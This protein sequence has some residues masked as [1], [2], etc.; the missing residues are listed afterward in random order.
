MEN[1]DFE[2]ISN[3]TIDSVVETP[4]VKQED[5]S[6][7]DTTTIQH[8]T[9]FETKPTTF[10]K[11]SLKRFSKNKSSVVAAGI[12]GAL[13][14]LSFVVPIFNTNNVSKAHPYQTYLEP[15]LFPSG[16]GWWDGTRKYSGI[17]YDTKTGYPDPTGFPA[18]EAI[19]NLK[20]GEKT[21]VNTTSN[22]GVGG[23]IQF[24][25]SEAS[26]TV[27]GG[28]KANT[29]TLSTL[30]FAKELSTEFENTI[31]IVFGEEQEIDYYKFLPYSIYF[32][33]QVYGL[34]EDGTYGYTDKSIPLMENSTNYGTINLDVSNIIKN[35]SEPLTSASKSSISIVISNKD[36]EYK[37]CVL[38]KSVKL[39][40]NSTDEEFKA[41]F[42]APSFDDANKMA[43]RESKINEKN[44]NP[45][46]WKCTGFKN[47]R[48]VE[49]ITC[50]F[51]YDTYIAAFGVKENFTMAGS[52]VDLYI[53]KGWCKYDKD[54]GPTSFEKLSDKCPIIEVS[55]QRI[56]QISGLP[57][58]YELVCKVNKYALEEYGAYSHM[59][60]F[61][62]GTDKSGRDMFKYVF[63]GLRTSLLLGI[64]TFLFCFTFGLI[65]G[66]ISGYFG[67]AVDLTMERLT[68]ILSGVPWIV[69]MTL[70]I[71]HLGSNFITFALA[72]C[73]TGWIGTAS[74]TRT[75][76]YRFRD[77]EYV[78][79]SRTLGASDLRLI[80]KHILPNALGTIITSSVL[81]IP[82]VIFSEATI[83][84]LGLGLK[85]MS[86][87]GVILSDNQSELLNRPYLLLFPSIIIA[88]TMIS[89][90]LFGNGLRDAINPSLKGEE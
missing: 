35:Y 58:S 24:S 25:V 23:Y 29:V 77:R 51:T 14:L 52:Q 17:A 30:K 4:E 84:Y 83:S 26:E 10:F 82:S 43:L 56:V 40:T 54:V 72:L 7:I 74:L 5:F 90:N 73:L 78:L 9:K 65:W 2:M 6:F 16:T 20:I 57:D 18:R 34:L 86:S 62:F 37:G 19:S 41:S 50:S 49:I 42:E 59:P 33:Y 28:I 75:Q 12:L 71:I 15:K 63:E 45:A 47:V 79:A 1:K 88:L 60:T 53:E 38:I 68:D 8:E 55:E 13:L 11:D 80:F 69:V 66:S 46:Y 39:T 48:D 27:D 61:L 81:M 67:G 85:S 32:N 44:D 21:K 87:L 3:N 70:V 89:F 31:Q 64:C 76:F 22:Y 36:L